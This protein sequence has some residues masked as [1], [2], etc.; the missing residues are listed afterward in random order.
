[1]MRFLLFGAV[2]AGAA[3]AWAQAPAPDPSKAFTPPVARSASVPYP[4]NAPT[5]TEPVAV[6][7]KLTVDAA[8]KVTH[9]EIVGDAHPVFDDAV[10][11]AVRAFDFDP[12]TYDGKP[13]AV[14]IAFT[15]TFLPPPPAPAPAADDGPPVNAV[16]RGKV[17]ELGTRG[18]VA[19]ATVTATAGGRSYTA[20]SDARGHFVLALPEGDAR[21]VVNAPGHN[22]FLQ[23]EKLVR[24]QELAVTYLVERDRYD[25]Y[26]IVV[27]GEQRREE[28]S[29]IALRG[30]EIKQVPGTFGDPFRVVQALPGVSSIVSLLPFPIVRG[31]S[32]AS[33]V[34]SLDGIPIPLLYHLGAGP[35]V[36]HPELIDELLFYPGGAPAPYGRYRV[37]PGPGQQRNVAVVLGLPAPARRRN[38]EPRLDG[39]RVRCTRRARQPRIPPARRGRAA[40]P[41]A[42]LAVGQGRA[43]GATRRSP[44][45]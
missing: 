36:V 22:A 13:V 23:R 12:A 1:M 34:A 3:T 30:A 18:P 21:I 15:H 16:L 31:N 40:P 5:H 25:P 45:G 7:A 27:I 2:I 43:Q 11:A 29:R 14:E 9:A 39:V 28:V 4:A 17:V 20:D 35:S 19:T 44:R 32:P 10:L 6:T 42:R 37:H 38:R 26:E 33:T 41:R 24:G 8:G